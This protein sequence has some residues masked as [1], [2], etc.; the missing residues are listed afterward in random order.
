MLSLSE[1]TAHRIAVYT[2][3]DFNPLSAEDVEK[4]LQS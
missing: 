2:L 3:E 4:N 1:A